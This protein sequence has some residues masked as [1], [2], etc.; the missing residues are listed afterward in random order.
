MEYQAF[1][2]IWTFLPIIVKIRNNRLIGQNHFWSNKNVHQNVPNNPQMWGTC[3]RLK[4]RV[5]R[6]SSI[7]GGLGL[8]FTAFHRTRG[9]RTVLLM[10][11]SNH[12]RIVL[13]TKMCCPLEWT[14]LF[15]HQS[16]SMSW[17]YCSLLV[18]VP[19]D[20]V[21]QNW[22]QCLSGWL[23]STVIQYWWVLIRWCGH[24]LFR[25]KI[26]YFC[27]FRTRNK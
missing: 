25:C 21:L 1:V 2:I 26:N 24:W 3:G 18:Q 23:K 13:Q 6:A 9:T 5:V 17:S 20:V 14:L 12:Q 8:F 10:E 15:F 7:W 11:S 22:T 16:I 4:C 19:W 27:E